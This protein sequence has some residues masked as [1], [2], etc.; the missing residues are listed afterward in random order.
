MA[1][2]L[3]HLLEDGQRPR[4]AMVG[5]ESEK[6]IDQTDGRHIRVAEGRLYGRKKTK[7]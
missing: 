1:L 3:V 6:N 5:A 2:L 4:A 7:V